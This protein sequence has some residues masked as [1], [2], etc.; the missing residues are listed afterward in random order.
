[1][2][3]AVLSD[4]HSNNIALQACIDYINEQKVD[5]VIFLGDNISDC[6]N[7][8]ATLDLIKELDNRY[9]T[10]HINGNREE[11]FIKHQDKDEDF[12]EWSYSSEKGSLLY[13][14]ENLTKEDIDYFRS[15][16]NHGVVKIEG[17]EPITIVHGSPGST[18]ELLYEE[19]ENTNVYLESIETSYLLCGH[20]H[21]Q[22]TYSHHEKILINPGSVG[23]AIGVKKMANIAIL[24]WDI[25][26][27][28][29]NYQLISLPFDFAR[30]RNIFYESE[31]MEKA[32]LWPLCILKSMETGINYAPICAKLAYDLAVAGGETL[33][34]SLG[35]PEKYWQ[36]AATHIL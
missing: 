14:Y 32:K 36:E 20:S 26:L 21:R 31:L 27:N 22:F 17:T 18:R 35:V 2:K 25:S 15:C 1:M 11:Y 13:T 16:S 7:P 12:K 23:V 30:L 33:G 6:P 24:E 4:I 9:Q 28:H 29:W 10:W 8:R 5:G 34:S 19:Q 3:L